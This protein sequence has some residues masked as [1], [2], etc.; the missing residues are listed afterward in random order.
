MRKHKRSLI[1]VQKLL[2]NQR[3]T[4]IGYR[5]AWRACFKPSQS[6]KG[7]SRAVA[8]NQRQYDNSECVQFV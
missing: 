3:G 5:T 1:H 7:L 8:K 4:C 6:T 2:E